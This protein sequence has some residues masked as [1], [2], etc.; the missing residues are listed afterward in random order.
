MEREIIQK[1][2]LVLKEQ[3]D[4]QIEQELLDKHS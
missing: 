1:H 4:T 2:S 3:E